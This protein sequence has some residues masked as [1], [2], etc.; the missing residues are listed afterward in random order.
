MGCGSLLLLA[1]FRERVKLLPQG[2]HITYAGVSGQGS[3][4]GRHRELH[5]ST[6]RHCLPLMLVIAIGGHLAY[7]QQALPQQRGC[8]PGSTIYVLQVTLRHQHP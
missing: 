5:I 8:I 3:E 2:I 6:M 1:V 4:P 7:D